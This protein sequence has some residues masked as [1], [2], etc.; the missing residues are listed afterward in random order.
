M[1]EGANPYVWAINVDVVTGFVAGFVAR[2]VA[3]FVAGLVAEFVTVFETVAS[4]FVAVTGEKA[5]TDPV[6]GIAEM[7]MC[8]LFPIFAILPR[9]ALACCPLRPRFCDVGTGTSTV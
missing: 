7:D 2:F 1:S 6:G 9:K 5:A 8:G 3:G 4:A